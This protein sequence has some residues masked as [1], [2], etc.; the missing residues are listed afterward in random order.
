[1][2]N[3][4]AIDPF[5]NVVHYDTIDATLN[6]EIVDIKVRPAAHFAANNGVPEQCVIPAQ[7]P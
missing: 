4:L 6:R 2:S 7:R 3:S 5:N 1:M